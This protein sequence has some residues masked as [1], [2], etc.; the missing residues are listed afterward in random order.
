M[1]LLKNIIPI[2][3]LAGCATGNKLPKSYDFTPALL[4]ASSAKQTADIGF[5]IVSEIQTLVYPR[6]LT[7]DIPLWEN[8]DKKIQISKERFVQLENSA[9]SP[10]VASNDMFIHEAWQLFKR[11][12]D[13]GIL[14]F[15]FSGIS[16]NG[17]KINYGY[18]DAA[19]VIDLMRIQYIPNNANGNS[20][21]TFW[22][23]LQS[24]TF[25]SNLV[26]FEK[27]DFRTNPQLAFELKY[28][29]M[30]DPK[31]YR[32]F[33]KIIPEKEIE[34]KVLSPSINS[35]SDNELFYNLV[36]RAINENKQV[37][38]NA[39]KSGHFSIV[40]NKYLKFDNITI[41][42]KWTQKNNLPFQE[43]KGMEVFTEGHSVYLDKVA[44]DELSIK[45]NLQG[46]EEYVSEK[47][48]SFLLQRINNQ[49]IN[50]REAEAFYNALQRNNWNK[51]QQ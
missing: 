8:S 37:L 44:I 29:A 41:T 25:Q 14:G 46:F 49:E 35:N 19:D 48:Y 12:F 1:H 50:P 39:D 7:G 34:Y 24:N 43:L 9:N 23:A 26:Q 3:L 40:S 27:N 10:F 45:I 32:D 38:L 15:S 51:I 2:L 20:S 31:I 4:H 6:L 28:Q 47:R 17:N 36:E 5:N 18:I 21:L 30:E 11:N 16:K 33:Y 42:E 22:D 13:F